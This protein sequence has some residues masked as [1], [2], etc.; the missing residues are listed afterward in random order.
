MSKQKENFVVELDETRKWYRNGKLHHI[1]GS[2]VECSDGMKVWLVNGE[3]VDLLTNT[4]MT[5]ECS[6][7][8]KK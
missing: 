8:G 5:N 4:R 1:D 2:A 6:H 7:E 3:K